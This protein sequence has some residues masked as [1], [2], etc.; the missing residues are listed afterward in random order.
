MTEADQ[1][2]PGIGAQGWGLTAKRQEKTFEGDR[3]VLCLD[4]GEIHQT[5]HTELINFIICKL[6]LGRAGK[7][8]FPQ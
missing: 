8:Y 5:V 7:C 4:V 2:L 3:A 1:W 6:Y